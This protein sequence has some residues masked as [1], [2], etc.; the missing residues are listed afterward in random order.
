MVPKGDLYL[1]A[2]LDRDVSRTTAISRIL[3]IGELLRSH[4][5]ATTSTDERSSDH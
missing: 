4:W 3:R 1:G 2:C 5:I